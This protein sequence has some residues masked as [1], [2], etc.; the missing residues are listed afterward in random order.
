MV[1]LTCL[2]VRQLII[3][4]ASKILFALFGIQSECF[5]RIA[6]WVCIAVVLVHASMYAYLCVY[7]YVYVGCNS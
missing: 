3:P 5:I 1:D 6:V 4:L 2:L 7:V